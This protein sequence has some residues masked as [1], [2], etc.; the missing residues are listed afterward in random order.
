M[1][2]IAKKTN[3]KMGDILN[4]EMFRVH[5]IRR[6]DEII[7][8]TDGERYIEIPKA[9]FQIMFQVA[10]CITTHKSQGQTFNNEYQIHEWHLMDSRLKYVA[11]SR[12]T[13][14][15]LIHLA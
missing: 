4:N 9:Q 14:K 12:A 10:F 1:P 13:K 3:L 7:E 2:I 11:L 15:E 5:K 6:D 8:I